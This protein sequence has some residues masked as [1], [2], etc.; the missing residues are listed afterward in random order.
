M[1]ISEI[2]NRLAAVVPQFTTRFSTPVTITSAI[3]ADN[4]ITV[5]T[6]TPHGLVSGQA[7]SLANGRVQHSIT[8]ITKVGT[9]VTVVLPRNHQLTE[10]WFV[11]TIELTGVTETDYN[12]VH[13]FTRIPNRRTIV[14]EVPEGWDDPTGASIKL[15]ETLTTGLNGS[16]EATVTSPTTYTIDAPDLLTDTPLVN[17][18]MSMG[19][20]MIGS[21]HIERF[22]ENYESKHNDLEW[23]VVIPDDAVVSKDRKLNMD[24]VHAQGSGSNEGRQVLLE[25][26]SVYAVLN[27]KNDGAAI[28]AIDACMEE[29]RNALVGALSGY[30]FNTGFANASTAGTA[31]TGHN[32]VGYSKAY[33]IHEFKFET[34][35]EITDEDARFNVLSLQNSN[36]A[37]RDITVNLEN[38]FEVTVQTSDINLDDEPL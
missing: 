12:A 7:V 27:C 4:V 36:V 20:R 22:L 29:I 26:F 9:E 10:D 24:A 35:K 13:T 28:K 17:C 31:F 33:Y 11:D 37:F 14:F 2:V 3:S 16:Y 5:T 15:I 19:H 38:E 18:T 1:K 25:P 32:F 21:V 23:L 8:S 6:A 34:V 30:K